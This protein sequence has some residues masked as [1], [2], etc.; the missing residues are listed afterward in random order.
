MLWRELSFQGQRYHRLNNSGLMS[1][2]GKQKPQIQ[3]KEVLFLPY[4]L[5][6]SLEIYP[7]SL[8]SPPFPE[9]VGLRMP[10][11][12]PKLRGGR[13]LALAQRWKQVHTDHLSPSRCFQLQPCHLQIGL[14]F[15][16]WSVSWLEKGTHLLGENLSACIALSLGVQL[17]L[18]HYKHL[19]HAYWTLSLP[20]WI[21]DLAK[22]DPRTK[23]ITMQ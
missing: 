23:V 21:L 3:S 19:T 6:S 22:N 9:L 10:L 11:S 4:V 14:H 7:P 15:G 13:Q 1:S 5:V 18:N 20:P 16:S 8:Q 12:G 2:K 17:S